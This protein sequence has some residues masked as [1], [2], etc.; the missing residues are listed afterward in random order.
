[1]P[2]GQRDGSLRPYSRIS[3]PEPLL[4]LSSSSSVILYDTVIATKF[5]YILTP[6]IFLYS[7]HVSV[8]TGHPQVRYTISYFSVFEDGP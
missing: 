7:L 6:F 3:I 2:G 5:Q 4:F 8:P 1:V